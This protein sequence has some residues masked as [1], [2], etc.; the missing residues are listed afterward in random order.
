MQA[1]K[2]GPKKNLPGAKKGKGPKDA[3]KMSGKKNGDVKQEAG[4]S[5]M[6]ETKPEAAQAP[7][8]AADREKKKPAP[9]KAVEPSIKELLLK[10][11]DS[12][13][14]GKATPGDQKGKEKP[15][16][17][18]DAPPFVTGADKEETDRIRAL[19]FK[20]FDLTGTPQAVEARPAAEQPPVDERAPVKAAAGPAKDDTHAPIDDFTRP[21]YVPPTWVL[22]GTPSGTAKAIRGGLYGLAVLITIV[23]G[24]SLSNAGKYQLKQV[25][26]VVQVWKGKFAPSGVQ[27]V[28]SLDGMEMPQPAQDVYSER[29]VQR[30]VFNFFQTKT[31]AIL[32]AT[33]YPDFGQIREYLRQAAAY[34]PS[35]ELRKKV[36]ARLRGIDFLVLL[37]KADIAMAGGTKRDMEAAKAYLEQARSTSSSEFERE[38]LEK[39]LA[40]VQDALSSQGAG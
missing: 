37:C 3:V 14:P 30:V 35:E 6:A 21:R 15:V 23:A 25:D 33:A 34:A 11:F 38:M 1:K 9:G 2:T 39:R 32:T 22:T 16:N 28:L 8:A 29:E 26:G 5:K 31:D 19:L 7:A 20:Q 18:P 10:R 17:I 27:L 24:I 40:A 13:A 12:A 36:E 4:P